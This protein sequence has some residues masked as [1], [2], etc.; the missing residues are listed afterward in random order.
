MVDS[1]AVALVP[2]GRDAIAALADDDLRNASERCG[3][4][5]PQYFL[6]STWRFLWRLRRQQLVEHPEDELWVAGALVEVSS[7]NVVGHA[8]FH[9]APDER[10]MVEVGY[11]V[12]PS[13]RGMGF[14]HGAL[15]LLLERAS[16]EPL[17]EVVRASIAPANIAS[18]RIVERAGFTLVGSQIDEEDGLELV[19]ELLAARI[20]HN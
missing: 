8:G 18:R 16:T 19:F 4:V 9:G 12:A 6:D 14:G 17:V 15:R 10:G 5:L 3:L 13:F 7:G 2:L 20:P 1:V 11:A